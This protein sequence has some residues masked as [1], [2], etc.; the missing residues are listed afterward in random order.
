MSRVPSIP[1]RPI[2]PLDE[3]EAMLNVSDDEGKRRQ[4]E[5]IRDEL[6]RIG[7]EIAA[8]AKTPKNR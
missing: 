7:N 2:T 4:A 5:F 1:R 3:I 6:A 8:P